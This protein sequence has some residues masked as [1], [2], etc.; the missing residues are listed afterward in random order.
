MREM[1]GEM[2]RGVLAAIAVIVVFAGL[3][4]LEAKDKKQQR[5]IFY[6]PNYEETDIDPPECGGTMMVA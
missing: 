2:K 3:S 6:R 1:E 4:S 5:P